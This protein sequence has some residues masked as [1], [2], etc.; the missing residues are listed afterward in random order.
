MATK[1]PPLTLVG[2]EALGMECRAGGST[3]MYGWCKI[4]KEHGWDPWVRT[5]SFE[6]FADGWYGKALDEWLNL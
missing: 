2:L 4:C 6:A 5:P 3:L 1:P